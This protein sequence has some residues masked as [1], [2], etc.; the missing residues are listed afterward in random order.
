MPMGTGTA[1]SEKDLAN[2][3]LPPPPE[4]DSNLDVL[5]RP[6]LLAD[7]E[8]ILERISNAINV[9][10]NAVFEK[11]G[12]HVVY[13]KN[14]N[15]WDERTIK[16]LKRTESTMV[17]A[18]GVQPGETVALGDPTAKP[19]DKKKEK[20]ASAPMGMPSGGG[21]GGGRAGG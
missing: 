3:K 20:P 10:A 7:V 4:S 6:G 8:I 17:I 16:P 15:R 9:P 21:G 1:F 11:D 19:G 18:S 13:V 2:A 5:I 14:G 12:K